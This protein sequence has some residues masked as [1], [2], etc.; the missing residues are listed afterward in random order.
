MTHQ[1][2]FLVIGSGIAGL[3]YA[4]KVSQHGTVGIITI[5]IAGSAKFYRLN[6]PRPS[7]ITS[8]KKVGSN[9]VITYQAQ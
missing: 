6:G 5:P 8:I 4:L 1:F 2:D 3:S 7:A 9:V